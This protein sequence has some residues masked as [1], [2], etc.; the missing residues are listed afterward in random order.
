MYVNDS[1]TQLILGR[2][3]Q[4]YFVFPLSTL[5]L[6]QELT[7]GNNYRMSL[8]VTGTD[9]VNLQAM[10]ERQTATGWLLIGQTSAVDTSPTRH[11]TAG[12]VGFSGYIFDGYVYDNFLRTNLAP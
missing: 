12:S 10:V 5:N 6:S 3:E 8:Q 7:S 9:P 2:Q 1:G 11:T 4:N